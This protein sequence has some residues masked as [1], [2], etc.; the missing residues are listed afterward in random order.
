MHA[1]RQAKRGGLGAA[2]VLA[3]VGI[4]GCATRVEAPQAPIAGHETRAVTIAVTVATN[5]RGLPA[6][7]PEVLGDWV[8]LAAVE[9]AHAGIELKV[10]SVTYMRSSEARLKTRRGR[11]ALAARTDSAL[12]VA[13]VHGMGPRTRGVWTPREGVVLVSGTAGATT[14]SHELGHALGLDHQTDPSNI[15]CSC[16]RGASPTFS[17]TQRR[18]LW[19]AVGASRF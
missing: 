1:R 19:A 3:A 13:F 4:G 11:R 14:L 5:A 9:F 17:A 12:P 2:L 6:V 7:S 10:A 15:M 18:H 8:G 16:Q